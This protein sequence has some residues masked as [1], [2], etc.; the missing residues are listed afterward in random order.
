MELPLLMVTAFSLTI[1]LAM[2]A[3][4]SKQ[5]IFDITSPSKESKPMS[6]R[7]SDYEKGIRDV[8]IRTDKLF[9]KPRAPIN[10]LAKPADIDGAPPPPAPVPILRIKT[11]K[12]NNFSPFFRGYNRKGPSTV[13]P[14][15]R[16]YY[17][18]K[19]QRIDRP[20]IKDM[21]GNVTAWAR[22]YYSLFG[23]YASR[24][25]ERMSESVSKTVPISRN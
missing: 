2:P 19:M 25:A 10:K 21:W 5:R 12:G 17:E 24:I 9:G 4:P 8:V 11:Q 18:Q 22:K 7:E 3:D 16:Y 6:A 20:S 13:P 15:V 14:H 23:N 1:A